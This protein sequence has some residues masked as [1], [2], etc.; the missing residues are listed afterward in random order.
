VPSDAAG[1]P[2]GEVLELAVQ[3]MTCSHCSSSVER[4]L[5]ELPGVTGCRVVLA[6]GLA[7]V[8]GKQLDAAAAIAAVQALGYLAQVRHPDPGR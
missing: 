1:G 5:R 8:E 3:G 4:A 7:V 2:S 6:E